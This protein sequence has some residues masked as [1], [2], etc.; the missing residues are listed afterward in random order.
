MRDGLND[1]GIIIHDENSTF[2]YHLLFTIHEIQ[3]SDARR[4]TGRRWASRMESANFC[5]HRTV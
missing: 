4:P 3:L 5:V 2:T 1:V